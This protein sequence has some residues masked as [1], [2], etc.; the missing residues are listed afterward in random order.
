MSCFIQAPYLT[1][2]LDSGVVILGHE[3]PLHFTP[4]AVT[5]GQSMLWFK[6]QSLQVFSLVISPNPSNKISAQLIIFHRPRF[7]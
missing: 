2:F 6:E 7:P 5:I 4:S 1:T 3:F